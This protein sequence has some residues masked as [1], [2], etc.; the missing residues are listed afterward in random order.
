MHSV[1]ARTEARTESGKEKGIPQRIDRVG[2]YFLQADF[3][4]TGVLG[5]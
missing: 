3:L 2:V 5:K 1:T 4:K